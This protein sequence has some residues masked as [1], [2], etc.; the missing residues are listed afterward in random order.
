MEFRCK[1]PQPLIKVRFSQHYFSVLERFS[2]S[3][4]ATWQFEEKH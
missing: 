1:P 3:K 4:R 2:Y